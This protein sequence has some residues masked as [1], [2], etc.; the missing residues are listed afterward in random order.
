MDHEHGKSEVTISVDG[1]D[2]SI[3]RGHQTVANIKSAG[4]VIANYDLDQLVDGK[5]EPLL[6][7]GSVT[8]KGG[9]IFVSHPKDSS[10]S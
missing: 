8:I 10:S 2:V 7:E 9:E 4:N 3:H 1:K 5:L 6:D